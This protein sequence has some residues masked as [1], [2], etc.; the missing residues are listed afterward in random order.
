M[1]RT[2]RRLAYLLAALLLPVA[3]AAWLAFT[4]TGFRLLA[5]AVDAAGGERLS[6]DGIDGHLGAPLS[7]GRLVYNDGYKRFELESL[8]FEWHP[9]ALWQGRIEV[10]LLAVQTLRV[11]ELKPDPA[12][13]R[14]PD[15]LRLPFALQVRRFDLA[16]LDIG[17]GESRLVLRTLRA[18][19]DDDGERYA[20]SDASASTPWADVS[21]RLEIGKDAPFNLSA[22][23]DAAR[24][25]PLPV[26]A[27]MD[28]AG[29]LAEI[30]F[31]LEAGAE[32]MRLLASGVLAPF[33]SIRL[34]RLMVAG[35]GIDPRQFVP[36]APGADLAFAGVFEGQAG[37]RLLGNFS[38]VNRLPG[39]IDQQRLPLVDL[40]GAVLG[41]LQQA[42]F[43]DLAIN[44]GKAGSFGGEGQWRD[45]NLD[46]R[47]SS[48]R[49]DL[50][51]LHG[52]LHAT[53]LRTVLRLT[54]NAAGQKLAGEVQESWGEG[55]FALVHGA[56]TLRLEEASFAGQAGRLEAHGLLQLD[57]S[58]EF[59][60]GFEA[61]RINPAR[62]G[63]FPV[64][65]LNARGEASGALA[66]QLRVNLDF[67]LPP[68]ELEG[69]PVGGRGKLRIENRHV[70]EADVDLDLAGNTA[71]LKG[72]YGR[73]GDRLAWN[74]DAPALARLRLGLGGRLA[75][76][77]SLGGDP[78]Q[79]QIEGTLTAR[80]LRL[81]GGLAAGVLDLEL[82]MQAAADG[83]F[84]GRLDG[85]EITLA[86]RHLDRVRATAQGRRNA[87]GLALEAA[88]PEWRFD[89]VL[90]GGLDPALVWR[91]RAEQARL[92]GEWP[93]QLLAPARLELSRARQQASDL[94]LSVAGGQ[95]KIGHFSRDA[96]G[97]ASQG[98]LSRLPL[99]PAL[100]L[101]QAPPPLSTDLRVDGEWDLRVGDTLDGQLRLR[102]QS[103]DVRLADP[104]LD[105]GLSA[106]TLELDAA[107]SRVTARI[108]AASREAGRL[109]ADG[110]AVLMR[111]GMGFTLPRSAPLAWTAKLDVPD[112]RLIRPLLPVGV[113]MD[114]RVDAQLEG[115]GSL[116]APRI[117]GRIAARAIRFAMPEEG[118]SIADGSLDLVLDGDRVRVAQ[119][120]LRGQNGRIA[121][122][123]EAELRDPQA[124]LTLD[125]EKFSVTNRSDRRVSVS[126]VTR[127]AVS[128]KR[129][130][131]EGELTADRARIEMPEAGRPELSDDVV[132]AGQAPREKSA[133]RRIPLELDLRLGLGDDFL[134]KGAGLDARLGG[135]L[136]VY[137]RNAALYGE[138]RIQTERGHYSA[139]AQRLEIERGVLS[140]AGP[141][142][143]PALDVL[144]VRKTPTVKAGVQVRGTVQRPLVTLYSDPPLPD[145]EKLAWLVL[146]HGLEGG[147]Q[148]E[149]A[150]LQ[151][152]AG[153]LLSQAESASVQAQLAGALGLDSF[154]VRAGE[155]ENLAGTVVSVGRRLSSRASLSYEQGLDGLNQAVKV[156]YQLSP[157]VRVEARAGQP[158]S[159]DVFYTREFD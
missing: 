131:L 2:A 18:R 90:S 105:L 125:F 69:R 132:V 102:R 16:R 27:Q 37:E 93:M 99:A 144:A 46:L 34:P 119:G 153:A 100:A 14:R 42:D 60:A 139:Y 6:I 26:T 134:F 113:R 54:G 64:A 77:G 11:T 124:G 96:S 108:A 70:A 66:P 50:A 149:F 81:P 5:A 45:G 145:T 22:R 136:R 17:G 87:H 94:A 110:Q 74:I 86:G 32:A 120:V 151:L 24:Q 63:R 38:L 114:A 68:G 43:S 128:Q 44:L 109:Q 76:Q 129:L 71:K 48:P 67:S 52:D 28:L 36:A 117:D 147:G 123:G 92:Q 115:R 142:G 51:G 62:F 91:G 41:D 118:I 56:G 72:A 15:S 4:A 111:E 53:R 138:G 101:L 39:R 19:L 112:L 98:S 137:T 159:F 3:V 10:D 58:R 150:L 65:R 57:A 95:L 126:G 1:R 135:Q 30:R 127:L 55:R 152:A 75:S 78:R 82:D 31:N 88:S 40:A 155:G 140:F 130:R 133:A 49:L 59:S 84:N 12:P 73:A 21:G 83:I 35:E 156:M 141:I 104:A 97:L 7:I 107:A 122:S 154:E 143:N 157:H 148:Q 20:L 146:G 29:E 23:F 80:D 158:N 103:G 61:T 8:R 9:R 79:P 121:L 89:A 25:G 116:A 13:A 85:R 33:A 106:L 47:L